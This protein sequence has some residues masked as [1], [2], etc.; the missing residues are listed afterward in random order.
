MSALSHTPGPWRVEQLTPEGWAVVRMESSGA[1]F[2]R[3]EY[4]RDA[5]GAFRASLD[6][7]MLNLWERTASLITITY[8]D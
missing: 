2:I 3:N 1:K 7:A 8:G 5:M 6:A 4:P